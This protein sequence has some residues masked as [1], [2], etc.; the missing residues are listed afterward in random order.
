[1]MSRAELRMRGAGGIELPAALTGIMGL[2][3]SSR[4]THASV[5]PLDRRG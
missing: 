2:E 3:S 1:M 5:D 4:P